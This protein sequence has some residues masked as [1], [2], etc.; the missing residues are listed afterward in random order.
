VANRILILAAVLAVAAGGVAWAGGNRYSGDGYVFFSVDRP[1]GGSLADLLT[2]GAGG[3]GLL[4]K[5]LGVNADIGYQFARRSFTNG[6][7]LAS[8]NG[9]YHFVNRAKPAK[10]VPFVTAG[11]AIIFR[12]GHANLFNYG[13]GINYWFTSHAAFRAELRDYRARYGDYA[14]AFRFGL[15]FR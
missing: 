8:I 5:G 10:L 15:A 14:V 4:Y 11:Y 1:R 6:V 3:E 13:G 9:C 7:G 2:F 12:T